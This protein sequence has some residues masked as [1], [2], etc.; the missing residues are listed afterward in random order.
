MTLDRKALYYLQA[1]ETFHRRRLGGC[2]L[3]ETEHQ[4]RLN[5]VLAG[6]GSHRRWLEDKLQYSNELSLRKRLQELLRRVPPVTADLVKNKSKFVQLA[7]YTRNYLTH[8]D[9]RL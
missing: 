1:A 9:R 5:E 3:P 7:L 8:F 2:S 6:A 4:K